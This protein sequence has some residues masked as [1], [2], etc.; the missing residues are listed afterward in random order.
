[1]AHGIKEPRTRPLRPWTTPCKGTMI[2][3][4][5]PLVVEAVVL[6]ESSS[7]S[8]S[9]GWDDLRWNRVKVIWGG[10]K[11]ISNLKRKKNPWNLSY[12][13]DD[14]FGEEKEGK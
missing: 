7:S 10:G 14:A 9:S 12:V 11:G 3:M 5:A 1:M 8:S 2:L 4:A 13:S 6:E